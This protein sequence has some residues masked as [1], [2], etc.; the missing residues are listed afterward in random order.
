MSAKAAAVN[1]RPRF[2]APHA[3]S[4]VQTTVPDARGLA[5]S[6]L[7]LQGFGDS[8]TQ[9]VLG[10]AVLVLDVAGGAR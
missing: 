2:V 7:S 10:P 8:G 5:S 4:G 9:T 6:E 3:D 1:R